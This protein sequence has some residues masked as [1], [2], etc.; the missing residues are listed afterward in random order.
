M[1]NVC[2]L[3]AI[4]FFFLTACSTNQ[5]LFNNET[6]EVNNQKILQQYFS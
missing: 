2:L 4:C 5:A 1:K 6:A 3:A